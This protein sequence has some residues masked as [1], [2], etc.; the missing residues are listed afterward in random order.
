M[1]FDHITVDRYNGRIRV[2]NPAVRRSNI[3][4]WTLIAVSVQLHNPNHVAQ[5]DF[6]T[7][8]CIQYRGMDTHDM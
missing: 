3:V 8:L 6:F 5:L 4:D 7:I 2:K 1:Y